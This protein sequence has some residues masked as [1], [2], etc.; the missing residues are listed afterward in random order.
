MSTNLYS[1]DFL[2]PIDTGYIPKNL[3]TCQE[4]LGVS[5]ASGA[6]GAPGGTAEEPIDVTNVGSHKIES[7]I[8]T[9]FDKL[10]FKYKKENIEDTKNGMN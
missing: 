4:I 8:H 1:S 7:L 3:I 10:K 5:G 2:P 6:S 9:I